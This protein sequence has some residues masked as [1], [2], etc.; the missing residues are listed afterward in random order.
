MARFVKI[1]AFLD[2][3]PDCIEIVSY[4]DPRA[5][6]IRAKSAA[7]YRRRQ[8]AQAKIIAAAPTFVIGQTV[9]MANCPAFAKVVEINGLNVR[10]DNGRTFVATMLVAA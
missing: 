3:N 9:K 7:N 5:V 2:A 1:N 8:A 10:L 4:D 6:A